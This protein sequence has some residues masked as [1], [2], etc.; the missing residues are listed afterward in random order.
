MLGSRHVFAACL[1]E[2]WRLGAEEFE[3]D[4]YIFLGV[5]PTQQTRRGSQGVAIALSRTAA[6]AW[7]AAGS[8]AWRQSPR[9]MAVRLLVADPRKS[10]SP[11]GV[12]L[13][14]GYAPVS[15]ASQAEWDAYYADIAAVLL[16]AQPGDVVL[17]STDANASIGRGSL[18]GRD[19]ST[20]RAGAVGPYGLE[21][22]NDSG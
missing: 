8:P 16:H 2:T 22:M 10:K 20:R 11:L 7:R 14:N 15:S 5:A 19:E 4:G 17:L 9:V 3:Q 21:H 13:A 1:Q 12:L 6:T 18:G